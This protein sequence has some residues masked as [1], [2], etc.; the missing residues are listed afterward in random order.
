M[1]LDL[2][3]VTLFLSPL[4]RCVQSYIS[5]VFALSH[6][7]CNFCSCIKWR[8]I[9]FLRSWGQVTSVQQ[10]T[11]NKIYN[12]V[13]L[14]QKMFA[15]TC[16]GYLHDDNFQHAN[17]GHHICNILLYWSL[18]FRIVMISCNICPALDQSYVNISYK[19]PADGGRVRGRPN[20]TMNS[21]ADAKGGG[22][23]EMWFSWCKSIINWWRDLNRKKS[24]DYSP[25]GL[26]RNTTQANDWSLINPNERLITD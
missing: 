1:K 18:N 19:R 23:S 4:V 22:V 10:C 11:N 13:W 16:S 3:H 15:N 14:N 21:G 2:F 6:L 25:F 8:V 5:P 9:S 17:E 12:E 20:E 26:S 7:M 24:F